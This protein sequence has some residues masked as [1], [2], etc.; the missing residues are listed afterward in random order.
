MRGDMGCAILFSGDKREL[1]N[2]LSA[3]RQTSR[4]YLGAVGRE[5]S[6]LPDADFI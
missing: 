1:G 4:G 5:K 3:Y 6:E 2:Y